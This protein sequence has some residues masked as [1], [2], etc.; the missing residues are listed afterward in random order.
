MKKKHRADAVGGFCFFVVVFLFNFWYCACRLTLWDRAEETEAPFTQPLVSLDEPS[1][2]SQGDWMNDQRASGGD[3]TQVR[4]GTPAE[5]SK[6]AAAVCVCV[7]ASSDLRMRL[8]LSVLFLLM[9][10]TN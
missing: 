3:Y 4:C 7:C 9:P 10:R 6:A 8:A 2:V 5:S 1:E